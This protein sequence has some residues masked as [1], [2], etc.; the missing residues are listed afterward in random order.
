MA[1]KRLQII[2][3]FLILLIAFLVVV[4]LVRPFAAIVAFGLIVAILFEPINTRFE[5]RLKSPTLAALLTVVLVLVIAFI[6]IVFF[7]QLL[8]NEL[9]SIYDRFRS[10]DLVLDRQQLVQSLPVQL[11]DMIATFSRDL[12]SYLGRLTSNA[13][14]SFSS[15]LSSATGFVVS[16][17]VFLLTLFYLL[18]DGPRIKKFFI[19]IMPMAERQENRLIHRIVFAVNGV[20]KGSF[21]TA[22]SQGVMATI[23]FFIFGVPEPI[24]W[25]LFTIVAALVPTVGTALSLVPAVIYLLVTGQA[26]NAIGL[27]IWGAVAVGLIDNFLGPRLVGTRTQLHP[28]L[29]L[30]SILGGIQLFGILGFLIGPIVMAIFVALVDMYRTDFK[31]YVEQ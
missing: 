1:Y 29:V 15:V 27:A 16:F 8:F 24:I 10:G 26:G 2:T 4:F 12:N 7:G 5:A 18:R 17:F 28:L 23:G 6:P 30:L 21:L 19:D 11:Q 25:G 13:F 31:S 14:Q 22:V 3:F 20:V 9:N